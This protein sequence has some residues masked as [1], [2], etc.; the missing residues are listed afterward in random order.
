VFVEPIVE[1]P[2]DVMLKE[3]TDT[4]PPMTQSMELDLSALREIARDYLPYLKDQIVE[5]SDVWDR[6]DYIEVAKLAHSIKGSA[7]TFGLDEFT[8]PAAK[9]QHMAEGKADESEIEA[10]IATLVELAAKVN[11]D[12]FDN[13]I[14]PPV[15]SG[16]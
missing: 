16:K 6:R 4:L 11:F 1:E 5:L 7:G 12:D 9:L 10:G 14:V 13:S 2:A 15:E 8:E 3:E